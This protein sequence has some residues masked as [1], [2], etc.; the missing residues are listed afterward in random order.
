MKKSKS[1][2]KKSKSK[3]EITIYEYTYLIEYK[4]QLPNVPYIFVKIKSKRNIHEETDFVI[5]RSFSECGMWRLCAIEEKY[6]NNANGIYFYKGA[7]YTM[8]TFIVL[9][10]QFFVNQ[11]FDDLQLKQYDD[12]EDNIRSNTFFFEDNEDILQRIDN[13]FVDSDNKNSLTVKNYNCKN[14]YSRCVFGETIIDEFTYDSKSIDFFSNYHY[15]E[16]IGNPKPVDTFE[17]FKYENLSQEERENNYWPKIAENIM[18]DHT[19]NYGNTDVEINGNIYTVIIK[20]KNTKIDDHHSDSLKEILREENLIKDYSNGKHKLYFMIFSGTIKL[21]DKLKKINNNTGPYQFKNEDIILEDKIVPIYIVPYDIDNDEKDNSVYSVKS[22]GLYP[23]FSKF[24]YKNNS[25]KK[26]FFAKDS[27]LFMAKIFD[28]IKYCPEYYDTCT[29]QYKLN[30]D[31]YEK[32]SFFEE[33]KDKTLNK[34]VF[35]FGGKKKT[36]RYKKKKHT[37]SKKKLY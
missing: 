12:L 29:T 22:L 37:R 1:N 15:K 5:T 35:N 6:R 9:E 36:R 3:F 17:R 34:S 30:V 28:Y 25:N 14:E 21:S 2:E 4:F 8:S 20:K 11:I 26:A 10:L 16:S 31:T 18:I 7:N 19:I 23:I 33:L 13:I 24:S 32:I 27:E